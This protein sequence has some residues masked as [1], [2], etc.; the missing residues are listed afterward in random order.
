MFE[1]LLVL[2]LLLLEFPL[3]QYSTW[4]NSVKSNVLLPVLMLLF[5]YCTSCVCVCRVFFIK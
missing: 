2:L 5:A 4:S 3:V 1:L